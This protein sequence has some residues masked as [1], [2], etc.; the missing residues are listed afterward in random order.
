MRVN[1]YGNMPQIRQVLDRANTL[2]SEEKPTGPGL[3]MFQPL[4]TTTRSI[5][6]DGPSVKYAGTPY[7]NFYALVA[8]GFCA[9]MLI[10]TW[11]ILKIHPERIPIL[12]IPMLAFYF[13][14][15]FLL[16]YFV[17][18]DSCIVIRSAFS[19]WKNKIYSLDQIREITFEQYSTGRAGS[20][21]LRVTTMDFRTKVYPAA[22]LWAKDWRKLEAHLQSLNIPVRNHLLLI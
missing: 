6:T 7:I 3:R 1:S 14:L 12:L 9:G 8:Y 13:G 2:L 11:P 17:M 19:F 4:Q 15:G 5:T 10:L 21:A 22:G 16:H 18:F 20:N